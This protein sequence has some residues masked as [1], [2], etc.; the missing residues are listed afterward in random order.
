MI[1]LCSIWNYYSILP[2]E[3]EWIY[4]ECCIRSIQLWRR[5]AM[6]STVCGWE[7]RLMTIFCFDACKKTVFE[8]KSA[9]NLFRSCKRTWY[10]L[11]WLEIILEID[12]QRATDTTHNQSQQRP[13]GFIFETIHQKYNHR[14][15]HKELHINSQKP[16]IN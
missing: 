8:Q 6:M 13:N 2:V 15:E 9:W 10:Y 14:T 16:S 11:H 3:F 4:C 7:N 5:L 1:F 12:S